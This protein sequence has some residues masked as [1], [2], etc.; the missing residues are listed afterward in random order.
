MKLLHISDLHI[1]KRVKGYSLLYDQLYVL[2]QIINFTKDKNIDG[3]I[4]AGDIYDSSYPSNEAINAFDKFISELHSLGISCYVVSGNHDS[5]HR[6]SFGSNIMAKE[7][8]YFAKKYSGII[9]PIEADKNTN[10]W[11]IPFIRPID[12]REYYHDFAIG[13]Y[14]EMMQSV[15]RNLKID[16]NK[17]NILVAHQ[18]VTCSGKKPETSESETVSLGT[19]DNIDISNFTDFDY[20]A[21][22]HIHKP[23]AMGKETIRY[24]GS[25]LKYSFSEKNDVKSMVLID[26]KNQTIKIELIPYKTLHDMKEYT[27]TYI[28]LSQLPLT[29]DYVR[30]VLKEEDYITDIKK[31]LE[32]NFKNIMEITYDNAYTRKNNIIGKAELFKNKTPLELFNTFYELQNNKKLDKE[33]SKVI[34][35]IF[36]SMEAKDSETYKISN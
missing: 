19:L 7:N 4:I 33:K 32:N 6:V 31:K 21:L 11:L 13:S 10:I 25:L 22:G 30:I 12:V 17:I 8:I 15:I 2:N 27:G 14:E 29:E 36:N 18:F 3:I 16:K 26:I 9:E 23:Q 34:N 1:G 24:A 20:V 28:E 35:Q 5:I